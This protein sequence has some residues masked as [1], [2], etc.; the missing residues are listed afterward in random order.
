M[1][2]TVQ[3]LKFILE[4]DQKAFSSAERSSTMAKKRLAERRSER[5]PTNFLAS[6]KLAS[7]KRARTKKR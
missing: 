5:T 2:R 3:E 6:E 4:Q 1:Q 7:D